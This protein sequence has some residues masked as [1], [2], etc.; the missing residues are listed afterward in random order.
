MKKTL[1]I[2]ISLLASSTSSA[3]STSNYLAQAIAE[4]AEM[5]KH[6]FD[7]FYEDDGFSA[8]ARVDQN[9]P[10][11][12]RLSNTNPPRDTWPKNFEKQMLEFERDSE[13]KLWCSRFANIIP[14][15]AEL[16]SQDVVSATYQ[17]QPL[18]EPEDDEDERALLKHITGLVVVAKE[19]PAILSVTLN[20]AKSFKPMWFVKVTKLTM[21]ADCTRSESGQTY[22][23]RLASHT[24]AKVTLKRLVDKDLRVISNLSK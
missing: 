18:P 4:Q 23:S 21:S 8:T 12:Q 15:D 17:F 11:G 24:E 9:Q 19:R 1:L 6:S 22:L 20:A 5:P 13:T 16:V 10:M 14:Q 7:V 3:E 2:C